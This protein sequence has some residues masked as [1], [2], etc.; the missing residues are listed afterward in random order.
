MGSLLKSNGSELVVGSLIEALHRA[1]MGM[2]TGTNTGASRY[3][4]K[5]LENFAVPE[6]YYAKTVME[7]GVLGLMALLGL[8]GI[9]L[10]SGIRCLRS[11]ISRPNHSLAA[12][13]LGYLV[14]A[15]IY[16]SKGFPLDLDPMNV[17][18]WIYGG[19]LLG[20]YPHHSHEKPLK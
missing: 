10:A 6:N 13:L 12:A 5:D 17:L 7:I 14:I 15:M 3:V 11:D 18:F 19:L 20:L 16:N 1:P 8:F 2:G 9:L 4:V